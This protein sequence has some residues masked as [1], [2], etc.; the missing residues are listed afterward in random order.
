M[1][2][3]SLHFSILPNKQIWEKTIYFLFFHFSIPF[4]F[5]THRLFHSSNQMNSKERH[6][7]TYVLCCW[8][9]FFFF[10]LI[11]INVMCV[12]FVDEYKLDE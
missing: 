11:I 3:P 1:F 2:F 12:M 9:V 8:F 5:P 4:L 6:N 7:L 10:F